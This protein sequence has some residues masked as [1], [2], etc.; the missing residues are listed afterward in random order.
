[1]NVRQAMVKE[2]AP[3]DVICRQGGRADRAFVLRSG[4]VRA[5]VMPERE[6]AQTDTGRLGDGHEVARYLEREALLGVE[7]ALTGR[8]LTSLVAA[9]TAVV[10]E[11]PVDVR[12]VMAMIESEPGFGIAMARMLA[13]R[14]MDTSK[15]F[16]AQQRLANRFMRDFQGM[17]VDFYNVVQ[18]VNERAEGNDELLQ[19]LS[20]AKRT[21]SYSIGQV[22]GA[23]IT[24][25][26]RTLVEDAMAAFEAGTRRDVNPGELLCRRGDPSDAVYWLI[27]GRLSV[28]VG[29]RQFGGVRPGES[30]G[31][32]GALLG[33][34]APRPAD[35][36]ADEAGA[37]AV[38]S[39]DAF[40]DFLGA[41]PKLLINLCRLLCLRV[42]TFD[43]LAGEQGDA[44]KA[45]ARDYTGEHATFERDV[46]GLRDPLTTA[47]GDEE[48]PEVETLGHLRDEWAR[49]RDEL[50]GNVQPAS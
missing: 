45:L 20:A 18:D 37:A 39:V 8:Y 22:A 21:W 3:G 38:I 4:A 47:A 43:Q 34:N 5:V 40:H 31:E 33:E 16:N 32:I 17:C 41:N 15:G 36:H 23:D 13:R 11:L 9:D 50:A 42:K 35:I 26:A 30:V 44:L 1:M 27:A 2:Y 7:G 6:L 28:R 49:R 46:R 24:R 12:A 14:L 25:H 29:E 19:A 10:T 48:G